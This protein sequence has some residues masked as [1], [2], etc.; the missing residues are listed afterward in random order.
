MLTYRFPFYQITEIIGGKTQLV[1]A[2][3]YR[4]NT[5]T[6]WQGRMIVIIEQQFKT[7]QQIVVGIFPCNEL[8]VIKADAAV[9]EKL[10]GINNQR[11]AVLVNRMPQF[12]CYI[13]YTFNDYFA[14]LF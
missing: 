7:R 6:R 11:T 10:H 1:S 3:L 9:K 12:F 13:V 5:F 2:I 14:L 8:A 4:R